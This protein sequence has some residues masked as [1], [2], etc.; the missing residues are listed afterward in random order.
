MAIIILYQPKE[1]RVIFDRCFLKTDRVT[2][3]MIN[4]VIK[5]M[6]N[7]PYEFMLL[8]ISRLLY[9]SYNVAAKIVGIAK[10]K[11]Y[12]KITSFL[13]FLK[14]PAVIVAPALET[15]GIIAKA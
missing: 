6:A 9:A 14:I 1:L 15:P 5:P 13:I 8:N 10:I 4:E 2:A 11:E 3:A 7:S 12:S